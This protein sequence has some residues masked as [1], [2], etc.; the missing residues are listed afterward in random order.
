MPSF[1]YY[2]SMF[3]ICTV[4][5]ELRNRRMGRRIYCVWMTTI[6]FN[7]NGANKCSTGC[8]MLK[9]GRKFITKYQEVSRQYRGLALQSYVWIAIK[10]C[11]KNSSMLNIYYI[12]LR[13]HKSFPPGQQ[14]FEYFFFIREDLEKLCCTVENKKRTA[15]NIKHSGHWANNY[16]RGISRVLYGVL[17]P[18]VDS[19]RNC[20]NCFKSWGL[21]FT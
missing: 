9:W 21:W 16:T 2:W 13:S 10:I 17:T 11:I 12:N 14:L 4:Y 5:K 1:G 3:N 8:N 7:R 15:W 18:H 19:S 20:D 6:L